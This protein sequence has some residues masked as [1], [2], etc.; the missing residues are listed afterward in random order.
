MADESN[1]SEKATPHKLKEAQKKGQVSKSQELTGLFMLIT[2]FVALLMFSASIW[3]GLQQ[4]VVST[5]TSAGKI[6]VTNTSIFEVTFKL[7]LDVVELFSGVIF[8]LVLGAIIFNLFQTGPV[9]SSHPITPD[10]KKLNPVEGFKKLFAKKSLFDLFK[11]LLKVAV[12]SLVW[13]AVGSDWLLVVTDSY[14]MSF[15][16]FAIHWYDATVSVFI[17]LLSLLIPLAFLDWGF[18][19]WDFAKKMMMSQQDIKDEHKKR[20]GD[21]LVKQ[22]QK[23]IQKELLK[24]AA[25]LK[26]VK[27]ADVIIT[28]PQ[29][30]AVALS[31]IPNEML[32]PKVLAIGVDKNAATIRKIARAHNV[33]LIRNVPLARKL[34][35][36]SVA[37]GYIPEDCYADVASIFR[38]ILGLDKNAG[39]GRAL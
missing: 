33:P 35:K 25:S 26:S 28:N 3:E 10:W 38:E 16:S 32:A 18:N 27:D 11:A 2:F 23:Q 17:L 8:F 24:K 13:I 34:H 4:I 9:F 31:F 5:L 14:G 15:S 19:K 30:I 7:I 39:H 22:K 1:K 36:N 6:D 37:D 21:P 29:H 12:I 20:E